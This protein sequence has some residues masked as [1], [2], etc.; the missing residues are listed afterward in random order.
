VKQ[1]ALFISNYKYI[2]ISFNEGGVRYCTLEFINLLRL[3]FNLLYFPIEVKKTLFYRLKVRLGLNV[4]EDY[5]PGGYSKQIKDL[6]EKN[7]IRYIYLNMSN[8]ILF[9]KEIKKIFGTKVLIV[10]C[11]HGNDSGDF[12]HKVTRFHPR[13][14]FLFNAF[15]SYLL[16]R[17]I[18]IESLNRILYVDMVL[19]I[20]EIENAIE[21]WIGAPKSIFLPRILNNEFLEWSPVLGRIGFLG[22][23]SHPPNFYGIEAFCL[24]L[25]KLS[26]TNITLRIIGGPSEIGLK[27]KEKYPF[28]FYCGYLTNDEMQFEVS[29]WAIFLNPVFYYSRGASTKLAKGLNWGLPVISTEQGNRGYSLQSN[30]LLNAFS[31]SHMVELCLKTA[32]DK[33]RL[34]ELSNTSKEIV[35]NSKDNIQ[36]LNKLLDF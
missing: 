32:F 3:K 7:N 17:M 4:Y 19:S 6:I 11:S 12:L 18:K 36:Y 24:E 29:S 2:D 20:S 30:S 9:A 22:D 21:K 34:T 1:N 8:T 15:S 16:G 13:N 26:N 14:T 10:I 27:L 33:N 25:S 23:L 31:P 28:I 35:H 5:D